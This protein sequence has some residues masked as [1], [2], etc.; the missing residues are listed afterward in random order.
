MPGDS[1]ECRQHAD[2]HAELARLASTPE[3]R[4]IRFSPFK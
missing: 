2:R 4:A 3:A 1:K